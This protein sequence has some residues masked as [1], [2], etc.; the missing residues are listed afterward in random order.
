MAR[1][2]RLRCRR[3]CLALPLAALAGV[4]AGIAPVLAED[5]EM[6]W[7]ADAPR[8]DRAAELAPLGGTAL[9]GKREPEPKRSYTDEQGRAC[10]DYERSVVIDGE[11][12]TA[13]ATVCRDPTGR[14]VLSR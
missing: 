12:R 7:A 8:A 6:S 2:F 14:W 1:R 10:R 5:A 13:L 3:L 4:G 11:T 9:P